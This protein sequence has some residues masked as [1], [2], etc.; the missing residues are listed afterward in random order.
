MSSFKPKKETTPI[1]K[2]HKFI[3]VPKNTTKV[4]TS[5]AGKE[6]VQMVKEAQVFKDSR[7]EAPLGKAKKFDFIPQ[8]VASNEF[9]KNPLPSCRLIRL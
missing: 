8:S 2:G 6:E 3:F 5:S 9:T 1:D 7:G 4:D